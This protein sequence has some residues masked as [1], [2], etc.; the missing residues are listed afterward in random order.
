MQIYSFGWCFLIKIF[1]IIL[2]SGFNAPWF[3]TT[4]PGRVSGNR[5]MGDQ[6]MPLSPLTVLQESFMSLWCRKIQIFVQA[7]S[8]RKTTQVESSLSRCQKIQSN[9]TIRGR[10]QFANQK[11][12]IMWLYPFEIQF[13]V[14]LQ[15]LGCLLLLRTV[16]MYFRAVPPS[17]L[18][19][20]DYSWIPTL[21]WGF[22]LHPEF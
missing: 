4:I 7:Y 14:H 11:W 15:Y 1:Q 10:W 9:N 16:E 17:P 13:A 19:V 3:N 2:S 21:Q 18:A 20:K 8:Q 12:M 22:V 5:N 6:A